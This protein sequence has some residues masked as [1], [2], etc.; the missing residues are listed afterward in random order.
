MANSL[1]NGAAV[2]EAS[3]PPVDDGKVPTWGYHA[4]GRAEIFRLAPGEALPDG[5][6][7][8]PAAIAQQPKTKAKK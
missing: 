7:D 4:D 1:I 2:A 3:A 5:W 8:S 6:T